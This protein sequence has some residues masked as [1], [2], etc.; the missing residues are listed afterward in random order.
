MISSFITYLSSEKRYSAHTLQA[1][2]ND[3]I[4]FQKFLSQ[5]FEL[6]DP[7]HV[8]HFH[9]RGWIVA[10]TE[11]NISSRSINRKIATLKSFYKFLMARDYVESNPAER[12]KRLKTKRNL[13]TFIK[14]SEIKNLLDGIEFPEGFTGLR[15]KL[16]LELFYGTGTRL[17]ELMNLKHRDLNLFENT[18]RVLGKRNKERIIPIGHTLTYLIKEYINWKKKEGMESE[19]LLVT[20]EGKPVYPMFIYRKVKN[21]LSQ[22]TTLLKKSP[23]VLRHTFATHLLN[24]GADLNAVKDLLGHTSLAATQVYTHNSIE[25]LKAAFDQAHPKA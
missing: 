13:P 24:K 4:Q 16:L 12:L 17:S 20:D 7:T 21:Y 22:V 23:H 18:I 14:E 8:E 2:T 25:K 10:L 19:L 5:E 11:K 6:D 9:V 15:D 3:L 1:Y